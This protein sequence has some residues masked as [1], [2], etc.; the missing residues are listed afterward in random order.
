MKKKFYKTYYTKQ[1]KNFEGN[2]LQSLMRQTVARG[3]W[4]VA[5]GNQTVVRG[6]GQQFEETGQQ[7][8]ETGQQLEELDSSAMTSEGRMTPLMALGEFFL[9]HPYFLCQPNIFS[10]KNRYPK[11]PDQFSFKKR[12]TLSDL[13][14]LISIGILI[15]ANHQENFEDII[16]VKFYKEGRYPNLISHCQYSIVFFFHSGFHNPN[17]LE[18]IKYIIS[19]FINDPKYLNLKL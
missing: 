13:K 10:A 5:R 11:S 8:E 4:T 6:T 12:L 3:N 18:I 16:Q 2:V 15:R 7:L 1:T 17:Y 9:W 19:K 14:F